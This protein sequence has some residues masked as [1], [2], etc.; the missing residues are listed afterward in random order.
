MRL[1]VRARGRNAL[2]ASP[3]HPGLSSG[4]P[5]GVINGA[6]TL[7]LFSCDTTKNPVAPTV[8]PAAV[9]VGAPLVTPARRIRRHVNRR[10]A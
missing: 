7:Q 2:S 10:T 5:P 3:I 8:S 9:P 4:G 1:A 6:L